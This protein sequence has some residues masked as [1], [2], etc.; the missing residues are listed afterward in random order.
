MSSKQGEKKVFVREVT[1]VNDRDGD[2]ISNR[3]VEMSMFET[4]PPYVKVYLN[5]IANLT[6]LNASEHS[7]I[8]ELIY[9]MGYNNIVPA[10][11]PVKEI[12]AN[13]LGMKYNTLEKALKQLHKKGILIRKTRG[14]YIMD[15]NLFGRGSWKHVKK[16]RM[17]IDYAE[18][19]T[20]KINTDVSTQMGID[21]TEG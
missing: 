13:K 7:L 5:D 10:Y 21:W 18:D 2:V 4:E 20:K 12:M 6:G 17:T 8:H 16:I 3:K 9:N 11:K 19:G 14:L 15:P 1:E